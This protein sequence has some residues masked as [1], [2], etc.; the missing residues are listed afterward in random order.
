ME[1]ERKENVEVKKEVILMQNGAN[2]GAMRNWF[3]AG[4]GMYHYIISLYVSSS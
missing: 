1:V 2:S 4:E 3:I